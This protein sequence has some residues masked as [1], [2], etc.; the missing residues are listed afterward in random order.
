[1][2]STS[3]TPADQ[4]TYPTPPGQSHSPLVYRIEV[5]LHLDGTVTTQYE[6]RYVHERTSEGLRIPLGIPG[7]FRTLPLRDLDPE[8]TMHLLLLPSPWSSA[9]SGAQR[10]TPR[11]LDGQ[12]F[13]DRVVIASCYASPGQAV[14][15]RKALLALIAEWCK[16]Q[17]RFFRSA[18][19]KAKGSWWP[20]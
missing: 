7:P 11:R 5:S 6:A 13:P 9:V 14:R 3:Q 8:L 19:K 17:E 1:M 15:Y 10:D 16:E 20:W 2:T 4:D 12:A 18:H